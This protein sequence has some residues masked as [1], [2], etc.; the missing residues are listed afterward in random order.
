MVMTEMTNLN[1][2]HIPIRTCIGC[3]EQRSQAELHRCVLHADGSAGVDRTGDGRGAW[4]CGAGCFQVARRRRAFERAWH[5]SVRPEV[6]ERLEIEL[7]E[8]TN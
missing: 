3:S 2:L 4:L 7:S 5:T 1:D 8:L 6:L